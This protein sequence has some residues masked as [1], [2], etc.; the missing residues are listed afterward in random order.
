[1]CF[2]SERQRLDPEVLVHHLTAGCQTELRALQGWQCCT[3][4]VCYTIPMQSRLCTLV[5]LHNKSLWDLHLAAAVVIWHLVHKPVLP[6][7]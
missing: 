3:R 7:W 4:T 6:V 1:M 2:R 5:S